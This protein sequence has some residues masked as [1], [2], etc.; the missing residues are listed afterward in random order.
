MKNGRRWLTALLGVVAL[1][2]LLAL[3]ARGSVPE[4]AGRQGGPGSGLEASGV[5]G[6]DELVLAPSLGGRVAEVLVSAG[7]PVRQGQ[8]LLRLDPTLLDAQLAVGAARVALA[9]AGLGQLQ[10]GTRPGVI[11]VAEEQLNQARAARLGAQQALM[12]AKVLLANAQELDMQVAV[13][14]AQVVAEKARLARAI[15][16]KDAAE[17]AKNLA[18][19]GIE[20]IRTWSLPVPAPELPDE[21]RSATW[22]AWRAWAG[23]SAA[24]ATLEAAEAQLA[25]WRQVRG[26]PQQLNAQVEAAEAGL[27]VAEASV[28]SAQAQL[29][30]Y[31]AGA[32]AEQLAVSRARVGQAQAAL[33]ALR[34]QRSEMD[35]LAPANAVV[36]EQDV[37]AG[38]VVAPGTPVLVLADLSTVKVTVYVAE[39]RIAQ[40]AAGQSVAVAVDSFP[41]RRFEGHIERIADRPQYTPRNVATKE[42]RVNTVFAVEIRVGNS[43]GALKPGM[44]AD[45]AIA[46]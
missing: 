2:G 6:V 11:T 20:V 39:N 46:Q 19:Y 9:E 31:R 37:R 4:V 33:D 25:H 45:V 16:V 1:I 32:S 7:D 13:A 41:H 28:T 8:V 3:A 18:D 35:L 40:V 14:E 27:Q 43:D 38:E 12:D 44:A 23:V 42:Q 5:I 30:A 21:L 10:A 26:N 24:R 15:A 22:D 34:V 29:D 36:L 17:T